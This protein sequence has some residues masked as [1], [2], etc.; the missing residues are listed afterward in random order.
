MNI[1]IKLIEKLCNKLRQLSYEPVTSSL[2]ET[3]E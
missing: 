3:T 1:N 2:E